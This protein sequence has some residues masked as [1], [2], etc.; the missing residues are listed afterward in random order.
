[1]NKAIRQLEIGFLQRF[2]IL[3]SSL[4]CLQVISTE[5]L[6]LETR[7]NNRAILRQ[8]EQPKGILATSDRVVAAQS[9]STPGDRQRLLAGLRRR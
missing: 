9:R 1:M 4:G 6:S 2:L 7:N 8:Y 5:R 3:F